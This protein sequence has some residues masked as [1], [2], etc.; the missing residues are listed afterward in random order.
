MRE[1]LFRGKTLL[2][3]WIEGDLLNY[4]GCGKVHIVQHYLGAGGQE[5]IPESVG[6]FTGLT[7]KNGKKIFEGDIIK[8]KTTPEFAKVNSF[9]WE[10][11]GIIRFGY[12]D[13]GKSEAGRA[14]MGWYIEPLQSV[15]IKP[16]NYLVGH[17]Q[18]GLNQCDILNK[19]YPMEVI[20]NIHENPELLKGAEN[21]G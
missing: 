17:I 1:I 10:R 19:Y 8:Q 11:Y 2:G 12:Y 3:Q 21:N 20:G 13:W 18:A 14:S 15:S 7:D 4:L 6:Q 9:E 16:K 5:V